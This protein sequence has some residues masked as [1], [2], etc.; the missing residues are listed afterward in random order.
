MDGCVE[1]GHGGDGLMGQVMRLAVVPD[2]LNVIE[3][4]RVVGQ[5][6]DGQPGRAGGQRRART[7]TWI[8]PLSSTSTTGLAPWP[9]IGP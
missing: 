7:L 5:P 4:S 1:R 9:G 3:F 8:G 6:L 2:H